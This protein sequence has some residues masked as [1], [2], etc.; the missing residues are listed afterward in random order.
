[1]ALID[2][3]EIDLARRWRKINSSAGTFYTVRALYSLD[4]DLADELGATALP[5][6]AAYPT[7]FSAQTPT[8]I[9]LK[10]GTYLTEDSY[11]HL[12]GGSIQTSGYDGEIYRLTFNASGYTN[13]VAGDIFKTVVQGGNNA[14][15][16]YYNNTTRVWMVRKG[17][18]T[19]TNNTATTI[20]A[21]TGAGTT[22]T[23]GGVVTGEDGW[24]NLFVLGT[25]SHHEGTYLEQDG[26]PIDLVT[27][28][29]YASAPSSAID[30]L[31]QIRKA[32]SLIDS[33]VAIV[34]NRVNRDLANSIDSSTTGDTYDWFQVDLS[35]FGR[36]PVPLSTRPDLDD[37]LTNAQAEDLFDGTTA[38]VV[39]SADGPF[40]VDVDQDGTT[41]IYEGLI[42]ADETSNLN[43][44]SALKYFFRKGNTTAVDGTG[45][46]QAQLFR[47]L[48]AS[49]AVTKDSPI[50][51][52][53]GG[54][55]FYARGWV[56]N[57]V[58]AAD[59]SKYQVVTTSGTI[60]NPPVFYIRAVTGLSSG[61]KVV[62]VRRATSTRALTTEFTL[63]AGNDS[64]DGT[65]VIAESIPVDK[66]PTGFVRVF[67]N[68]G[69]EDRYA[70]TAWSGSTF[71]LSGTLSKTYSAG[72]NAYVPYIDTTASG[73]SVSSPLRYVS[74][75]DVILR[76][77][78]GSGVGKMVPFNSIYTL[79][80]ADSSVPATVIA[81]TINSNQEI[82]NDYIT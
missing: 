53:A 24:A 16:L 18:G 3:Y 14:T 60:K 20:T 48:N 37:T 11:L 62:L 17:T 10:D 12:N 33:G 73:S 45:G 27:A 46:I 79:S 21:G 9:T 2:D 54:T 75:R 74:D 28:G 44:W 5:G 4:M 63:A 36:N 30:I 31:L 29:Y 55:I 15:L 47:T 78:L 71:T 51:T 56:P 34:Y 61:Q 49:Y 72:N 23:S 1:M 80:N 65:L 6:Y 13:A 41:E 57:N 7:A 59:A 40:V 81:D 66:P 43:L 69:N 77:L 32:G 68:S 26:I 25:V 39:V 50:G 82:K 70:Y 58:A 8:D 38:T 35:G 42:D 22:A 64:G 76:V 19:L 52:I 67:D